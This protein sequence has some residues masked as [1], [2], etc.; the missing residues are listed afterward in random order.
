MEG[1]DRVYEARGPDERE[2][3][4]GTYGT[5]GAVVYLAAGREGTRVARAVRATVARGCRNRGISTLVADRQTL[6][7]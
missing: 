6:F 1:T 5:A 3:R 2:A 7:V 4:W